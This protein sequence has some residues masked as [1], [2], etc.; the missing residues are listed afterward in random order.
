MGRVAVVMGK[1]YPQGRFFKEHFLPASSPT[2]YLSG[3]VNR[4]GEQLRVISVLNR[5]DL[6][7]LMLTGPKE[8]FCSLIHKVSR[9]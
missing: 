1:A 7:G 8:W 3:G 9:F 5:I 6:Y 2:P 4:T